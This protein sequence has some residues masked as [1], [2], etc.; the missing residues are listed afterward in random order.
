MQELLIVHLVKQN[1]KLV[2]QVI[3]V[4]HVLEEEL[5]LQIVIVHKELPMLMEHVKIV[6]ICVLLVQVLLILVPLVKEIELMNQDVNVQQVNLKTNQLNNVK[7]VKVN[8]LLVV[9]QAHVQYV[10]EIE[11]QLQIVHVLIIIMKHM[12]KTVHNVATN[13]LHVLVIQ[14]IV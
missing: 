14:T 3:V 5:V 9:M 7:I 4:Y 8:V 11:L 10:K 12:V 2:I 6:H 1:V 13:V